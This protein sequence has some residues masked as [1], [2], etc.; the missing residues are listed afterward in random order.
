MLCAH[1][2][3]HFM[4]CEKTIMWQC[5]YPSKELTF[6]LSAFGGISSNVTWGLFM[7]FVLQ[8]CSR[9]QPDQHLHHH[10][11]RSSSERRHLG[12]KNHWVCCHCVL[13]GAWGCWSVFLWNSPP[14]AGK[15][16]SFLCSAAVIKSC[17]FL[18]TMQMWAWDV[19]CCV[20]S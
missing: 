17:C 8:Q 2:L 20:Q 11:A 9:W 7:R 5:L 18:S 14:T 10:R 3:K 4:N 16:L 15:V 13:Q 1:V 12:K 6:I 19:Y